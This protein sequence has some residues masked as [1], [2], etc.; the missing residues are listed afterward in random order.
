[1][2]LS[3][4][5]HAVIRIK[6]DWPIKFRHSW[7]SLSWYNFIHSNKFHWCSMLGKADYALE[8]GNDDFIVSN[9]LFLFILTL[10][11]ACNRY[12]INT[13]LHAYQEKVVWFPS[14]KFNNSTSSWIFLCCVKIKTCLPE[15][16]HGS[17][18]WQWSIVSHSAGVK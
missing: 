12:K 10:N 5:F 15:E 13:Y 17:L 9:K 8:L 3:R 4:Y 2:L 16:K 1:M 7:L 18:T 11:S 6:F 14:T